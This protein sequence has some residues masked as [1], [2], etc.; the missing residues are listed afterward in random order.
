MAE[1]ILIYILFFIVGM[2]ISWWAFPKKHFTENILLSLVITIFLNLILLLLLKS[3]GLT[4]TNGGILFIGIGV[5]WLAWQ[6][7]FRWRKA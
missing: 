4:T 7:I 3:F 1:P 2:G 5:G 6:R